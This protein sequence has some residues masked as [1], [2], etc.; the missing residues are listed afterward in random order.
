LAFNNRDFYT[1][2]R[3]QDD[4]QVQAALGLFD[5]ARSL[6]SASGRAPLRDKQ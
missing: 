6:T 4:E 1:L 2:I 5:Q 3:L